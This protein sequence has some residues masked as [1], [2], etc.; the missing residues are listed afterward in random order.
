MSILKAVKLFIRVDCKVDR[1]ENDGLNQFV[2]IIRHEFILLLASLLAD[3][4]SVRVTR[5]FS[6]PDYLSDG[7]AG[8]ETISDI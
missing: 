2:N 4:G 7:D 5:K 8:K 6:V 1:R 3:K